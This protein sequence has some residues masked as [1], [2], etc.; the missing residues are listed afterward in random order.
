MDTTREDSEFQIVKYYKVFGWFEML[1]NVTVVVNLILIFIELG[2]GVDDTCDVEETTS[3]GCQE[4]TLRY[5]SNNLNVA[6]VASNF[7][8]IA[9]EMMTDITQWE[10]MKCQ[11][12]E[13]LV[14]ECQSVKKVGSLIKCANYLATGLLMTSNGINDA[15]VVFNILKA[16]VFGIYMMVSFCLERGQNVVYNHVYLGMIS[17]TAANI[18]FVDAYYRS[19]EIFHLEFCSGS[20]D[21]S[22]LNDDCSYDT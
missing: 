8:C 13:E 3:Y 14:R 11:L 10:L 19:S 4:V 15:L 22:L 21:K 2:E 20:F 1:L 9:I 6:V 12:T 16:V 5:K 17:F 18:Y 7:L